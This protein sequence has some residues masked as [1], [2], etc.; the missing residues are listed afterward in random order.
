[1]ARSI[2]KVFDR[3]SHLSDKEIRLQANRYLDLKELFPK[4]KPNLR[5]K[6]NKYQANKIRRELREVEKI[7]DG[8]GIMERDFVPLKNAKRYY[9]GSRQA[10]SAIFK[11]RVHVR[12][13]TEI[14]KT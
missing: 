9:K 2:K 12:R 7:A 11:G 3:F 1:M 4:G 14:I 5:T 8:A 10:R 6:L 13:A